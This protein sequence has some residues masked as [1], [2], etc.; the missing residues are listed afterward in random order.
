MQMF[1]DMATGFGF[2][3]P[4]EVPSDQFKGVGVGFLQ[5]S[6]R[7]AHA[8]RRSLFQGHD[9]ERDFYRGFMF[10]QKLGRACRKNRRKFIGNGLLSARHWRDTTRP[11]LW[12]NTFGN[13]PSN[14]GNWRTKP[15]APAPDLR[16]C[17]VCFGDKARLGGLCGATVKLVW[18]GREANVCSVAAFL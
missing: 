14:G 5:G 16:Q 15:K 2:F 10:R 1:S 13:L 17:L 12:L 18:R 3:L 4:D 11:C 8:Y 7:A 9:L 6:R